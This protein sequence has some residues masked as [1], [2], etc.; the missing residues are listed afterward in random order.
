MTDVHCVPLYKSLLDAPQKVLNMET[1]YGRRLSC[2]RRGTARRSG[3]VEMQGRTAAIAAAEIQMKF[4]INY[5]TRETSLCSASFLGCQHD[6]A[7]IYCC[8]PSAGTCY[9]SIFPTRGA[10]SSKPAARRTPLLLSIDGTDGRT[11]GRS[12]VS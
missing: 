3:S 2:R 11:D 4:F 12:T 8:A 10:L 7:R 6:T 1:I 5:K 9:R